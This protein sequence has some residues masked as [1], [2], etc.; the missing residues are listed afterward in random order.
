[1]N[2]IRTLF[3]TA[4][5]VLCPV[6]VGYAQDTKAYE[7]KKARL[8]REIAIIDKQLA[9]NAS[10]SSSMLSDLT[11]IRKNISN[12][13][14]LVNEAD[15]RVRQYS[16]SIYL[17]QREINRL[18]ARIDTLT[19]HYAKLVRSAYKNRDAR[20]WYMYMLASDNLGQAF[21]RFGYFKN[22]SSQMKSEAKDIRVMQEELEGK[23][24]RL[25]A[26][27]AE[28]EALK[29]ERVKEL[30]KLKKD[31]AKAD[32]VVKKLQKDKKKYQNQ[33]ASK[34]KEVNAL[35]RQ[36]AK[37][38]EEAMKADDPKKQKS[39]SK[40]SA[41]VDMKLD[42]EFSKNKGKLPWPADGPVVGTFGKH[43]HPVY[44][45][46]ELPS[47]NGIDVA[48]AKGS[49]VKAVF[50]GTVTQVITMPGYNQCVLV[51][52]GN[53]FTLYCKMK[54]VSVKVGEKVKTGQKLGTIDTI[55]GQTQLHFEVW[56]GS[57]PQNPESW[58]R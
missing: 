36:I 17:A 1:M 4:I 25:T 16:D 24:Q 6:V 23:K 41:P 39:S 12:R 14:S 50:D 52:H 27:K 55:N 42:G 3:I 49:D 28:A 2:Q 34:K 8:E 20:V 47:N 46:L 56:K 30:E 10:Q 29:A 11:L 35:N 22:L 33:L 26:I 37:L 40:K 13:K 57:T 19:S 7:E 53:Y 58:L 21:R 44:K 32:S 9:E 15:R 54:S 18:Q 43:Y 51:Q 38:I 45:N 48:L 31:E 5:L